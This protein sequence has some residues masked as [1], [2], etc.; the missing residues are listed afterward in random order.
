MWVLT[1]PNYGGEQVLTENRIRTLVLLFAF[2]GA[3]HAAF[4]PVCDRTPAVKRF[5]ERALAKTCENISENDLLSVRRVATETGITEFKADD[6]SGLFNLE[7]LNIRSNRYTELPEG[8]FKDLVNMNTLV[9][10]STTLRHYPDDFLAYNPKIQ[11]LH[12]FRNKVTSISESIFKRLEEAKDLKVVDFD[13]T[14]QPAEKERLLKMFP[15]G[16]RVELSLI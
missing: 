4:L 13:D 11:N 6:F 14:L 9:I 10:I 16:G 7:I 5:L 3:A 12:V 8:L 2:S 1:K 15:P